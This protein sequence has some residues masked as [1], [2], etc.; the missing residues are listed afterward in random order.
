MLCTFG[1]VYPVDHSA[2]DGI[3]LLTTNLYAYALIALICKVIISAWLKLLVLY[4][5]LLFS[6]LCDTLLSHLLPCCMLV[7]ILLCL[8]PS[9][10]VAVPLGLAT[11]LCFG[12][13]VISL[14]CLRLVEQQD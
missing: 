10:K 13:E 2:G 11:Q 3:A 12:K 5:C 8:P 9:W 14:G 7:F 6:V 1:H 4:I